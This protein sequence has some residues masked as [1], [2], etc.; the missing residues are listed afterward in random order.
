LPGF[1]IEVVSGFVHVVGRHVIGIELHEAL[2]TRHKESSNIDLRDEL[3][4]VFREQVE[5]LF[6]RGPSVF[7][8]VESE[9]LEQGANDLLEAN[10]I[11]E[12]ADGVVCFVNVAKGFVLYGLRALRPSCCPAGPRGRANASCE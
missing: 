1:H 4:E 10:R 8:F 11:N 3:A 9:T 6:R 2:G 5:L 7:A 12:A